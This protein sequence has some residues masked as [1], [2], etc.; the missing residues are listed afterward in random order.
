MK[1]NHN[2][3]FYG[4]TVA[5]DFYQKIKLVNYIRKQIHNKQCIVCDL[6]CGHVEELLLH[7]EEEKHFSLPDLELFDQALYYFPTYE[8]DAFLYLIDDVED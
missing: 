7:M 8:N 5:L 3:D 1:K 2:F 4:T 6:K